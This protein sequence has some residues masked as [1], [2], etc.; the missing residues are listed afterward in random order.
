MSRWTASGLSAA[1]T[2][3]LAQARVQ[4][5]DLTGATLGLA[6]QLSGSVWLDADA[7]GQGWFVD[8]TP[9]SSEEFTRSAGGSYVALAGGVAAG[10]VDLLTV[11]AHELGH[12][13]G[14]D[15]LD[16]HDHAHDLMAGALARGRRTMPSSEFGEFGAGSLFG[17]GLPT[18]PLAR[19]QV[20]RTCPARPQV[21][22]TSPA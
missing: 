8:T 5:T 17:A 15:D 4:V 11:L 9:S 7:A 20:S 18:P 13:F 10:R 12:V 1:E 6:S 21:S 16:P 2:A 3:R 22:R 19:P 14:L